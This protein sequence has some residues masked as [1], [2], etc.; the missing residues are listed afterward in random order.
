MKH[1]K[2]LFKNYMMKL[3]TWKPK[4]QT[5]FKMFFFFSNVPGEKILD[6]WHTKNTCQSARLPL[7]TQT[8]Q[9]R[10]PNSPLDL[11]VA[12]ETVSTVTHTHVL[13]WGAQGSFCYRQDTKIYLDEKQ[14]CQKKR[15]L[16]QC[17]SSACKVEMRNKMEVQ[18]GV[19]V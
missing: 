16:N 19:D 11:S 15:S 2:Q 17:F 4:D 3:I 8:D 12:M 9:A 10:K 6:S 7:V 13:C 18:L 14:N 5:A 1:K